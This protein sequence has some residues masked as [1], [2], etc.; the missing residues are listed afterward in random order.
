MCIKP[1]PVLSGLVWVC[2]AVRR[3]PLS[4]FAVWVVG[5]EGFQTALRLTDDTLGPGLCL[6]V[7]LPVFSRAV[8]LA[9]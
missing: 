2:R 3:Q 7:Y 8:R 6:A 4:V 1:F 5:R 9:L